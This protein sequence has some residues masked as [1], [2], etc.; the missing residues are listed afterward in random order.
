MHELDLTRRGEIEKA[1][2]SEYR[3]NHGRM[4]QRLQGIV[5]IDAR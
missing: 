5:Q 2:L 3:A 4:R 1:A